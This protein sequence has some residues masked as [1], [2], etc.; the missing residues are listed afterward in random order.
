[1]NSIKN[2]KYI[3]YRCYYCKRII[4]KNMPIY[5]A[6]DR[7]HCSYKCQKIT[8]NLITELQLI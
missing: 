2:K 8:I 3:T 4:I 6:Y 7:I 1:M 5:M